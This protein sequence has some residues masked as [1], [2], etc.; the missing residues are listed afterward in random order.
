MAW[1]TR[2]PLNGISQH[3]PK[4]ENLMP[5]LPDSDSVSAG[6]TG[7]GAQKQRSPLF[8]RPKVS[9][10]SI[11][12]LLA[13]IGLAA[14]FM[15]R[16]WTREGTDDAF[17]DANI[18]F[19][20]PRVAGNV[21]ALH[22]NDNQLVSQ[23]DALFEIDPSIYQAVVNQDEQTVIAD[24]AKAASQQASYE[25]SVTHVQTVKA[26]FESTKASTE[27]ARASAE[28][29]NDDLAR[30]KALAATGVISA[31]EYDDSSKS[32]LA[33]IANL[34]SKPHSRT[35][36]APM[37]PKPA[38]RC[39]LPRRSGTP[40]RLLSGRLKPPWLR[41]NSSFPTQESSLR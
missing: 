39:N 16:A 29:L 23:G 24:E 22:V 11:I 12:V 38:S 30:N 28:Q 19:I 7:V 17:V 37:R 35:R 34:N 13:V 2:K 31:Q 1:N 18:I 15:A 6:K 4:F 26:I 5:A 14:L 25:Q 33:G 32:T 20:A 8:K 9:I 27:Q 3:L 21:I 36:P 10:A 41:R 40:P